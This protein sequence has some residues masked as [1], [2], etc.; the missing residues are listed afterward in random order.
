VGIDVYFGPFQMSTGETALTN[1][2]YRENS[3]C[4]FSHG[5]RASKRRRETQSCSA[6]D[7]RGNDA[8]CLL[9]KGGLSRVL[10]LPEISGIREAGEP[11]VEGLGLDESRVSRMM[12][13]TVEARHVV[14]RKRLR[15]SVAYQ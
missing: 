11:R 14:S 1:A 7:R 8:V 9:S 12:G 10:K 15:N 13:E 4:S 3:S 5:P 2:W 6:L